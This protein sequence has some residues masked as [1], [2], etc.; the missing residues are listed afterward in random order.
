[1]KKK[2][3]NLVKHVESRKFNGVI[4]DLSKMTDPAERNFHKAHLKAYLDG[5][6][7]FK[8]GFYTEPTTGQRLQAVHKV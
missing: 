4:P 1:M 3:P 7:V 2:K 5:R 6:T 8:Y